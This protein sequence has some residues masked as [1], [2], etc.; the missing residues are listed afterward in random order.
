MTVKAD[1]HPCIL[2]H[3]VDQARAQAVY[4]LILSVLY[5]V[6]QSHMH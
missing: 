6:S 5:T 4:L 1:A 2:L 3:S